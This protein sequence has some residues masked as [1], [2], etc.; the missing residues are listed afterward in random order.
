[1]FDLKALRQNIL[2]EN[3]PLSLL[4]KFNKSL[5]RKN[6]F[7]KLFSRVPIKNMSDGGLE[8]VNKNLFGGY[9]SIGNFEDENSSLKD[10]WE[11][12]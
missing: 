6:I 11:I 2:F 5:I 4:L 1:M 7:E 3:I 9:F 8:L 10:F 12:L